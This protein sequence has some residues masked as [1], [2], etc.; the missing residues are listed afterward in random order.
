MVSWMAGCTGVDSDG[1]LNVFNVERNDDDR[2]LNTNI[3]HPD[4][5]WNPENVWVFSRSYPHSFLSGACLWGVLFY[6]LSVP[7]TE[8]LTDFFE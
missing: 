5:T 8:H 7:T 4:N 6:Q 3:G 2:W 1:N